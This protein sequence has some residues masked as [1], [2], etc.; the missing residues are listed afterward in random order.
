MLKQ[1]AAAENGTLSYSLKQSS[2]DTG[3][4][5]DD[6]IIVGPAGRLSFRFGTS[7]GTGWT[8]F[9]VK[10]TAAAGWRWNWNARATQEQIHSVLANPTSLEIRG[11]YYTGPDEGALDNVVLEIRRVSRS[12]ALRTWRDLLVADHS[13]LRYS[14]NARRLSFVPIRDQTL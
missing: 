4:L 7:P 10:L 3:F 12:R 2:D 14:I 11:E 5:D 1:L 9:S 8:P 6:V 13:V